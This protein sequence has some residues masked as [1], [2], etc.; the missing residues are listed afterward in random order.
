M[1]L[2]DVKNVV[3]LEDDDVAIKMTSAQFKKVK[4]IV[5]ERAKIILETKTPEDDEFIQI[6]WLNN[7]L[8]L[9]NTKTI[10]SRDIL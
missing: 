1:K 9:A 5:V 3:V 2:N 6:F 4:S 8:K 7:L 10:D